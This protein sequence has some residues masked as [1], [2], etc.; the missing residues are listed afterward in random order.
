MRAAVDL[1]CLTD[2][3]GSGVAT[4]T[5]LMLEALSREPE[6]QQTSWVGLTTGGQHHVPTIPLVSERRHVG[7]SNTLL[8]A[9]MRFLNYPSLKHCIGDV[10]FF[11]QPNPMFISQGHTRQYVTVHDLSFLHF[12]DFFS[13]HT[14]AWYLRWVRDWLERAPKNTHLIT[15]SDFTFNDIQEHYPAWR[16]RITLQ[17]PP[18]PPLQSQRQMATSRYLLAVGTLEPRKNLEAVIAAYQILRRKDPE[19]QLVLAGRQTSALLRLLAREGHQGIVVKGYVSER[20]RS[21]LYQ[22]AWCLL[23]PSFLEGYGLPPL[24]AMSFGVPVIATQ[25]SSVPEYVG[26]AAILIDPYRA[27]EE[28][29]VAVTSLQDQSWYNEISRRGRERVLQ[30]HR[31]WSLNPLLT[32]WYNHTS[33]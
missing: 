9:S 17:R 29:V 28:I 16:G 26:D 13:F 3:Q 27:V 6:A 14:R 11:W 22:G 23:Y 19:L 21:Q 10:D 33:A 1:R 30:L 25:T 7:R 2:A 24:E 18:P 15:I 5:R 31:T 12:P 32:L 20:E 4:Y 8:N